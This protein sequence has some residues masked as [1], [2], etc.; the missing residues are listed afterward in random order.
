MENSRKQNLR[1][2]SRRLL[3]DVFRIAGMFP[4]HA[5]NGLSSRM[6]NSCV[7]ILANIIR[8]CYK[9]MG[10]ETAR[11]FSLSIGSLNELEYSIQMAHRLGV[12]PDADYLY[13]IGET[14][15]IEHLLAFF[16][17]QRN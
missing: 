12:L 9:D 5:A 14:D 15:A 17:R 3:L 1:E 7:G 10:D 6:R 13:L 11:F 8:G 2:R 4:K 16:M